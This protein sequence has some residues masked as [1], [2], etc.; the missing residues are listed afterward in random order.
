MSKNIYDLD[1]MIR[2]CAVSLLVSYIEE[3]EDDNEDLLEM[4][5]NGEID[6]HMIEY[7]TED[8]SYSELID[9]WEKCGIKTVDD[10]LSR[11]RHDYGCDEKFYSLDTMIDTYAIN[12]A[13]DDDSVLDRVREIFRKRAADM[14]AEVVEATP[15]IDDVGGVIKSFLI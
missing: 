14:V 9:G 10:I 5:M 2:E 7:A 6:L 4:F 12:Y 8:V 11:L 13:F 1:D 3:Y 15:L